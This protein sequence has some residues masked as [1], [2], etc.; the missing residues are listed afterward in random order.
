MLG[1]RYHEPRTHTS[2]IVKIRGKGKMNFGVHR[3]G[4]RLNGKVVVYT[5]KNA[6]VDIKIGGWY[7]ASY[8]EE[9]KRPDSNRW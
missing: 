6:R 4:K 5:L 7:N 3:R 8:N 1:N 9:P 2:S